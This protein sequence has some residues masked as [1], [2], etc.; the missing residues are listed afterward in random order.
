[1]DVLEAAQALEAQGHSVISFSLGEPDFPAPEVVKQAC[2][3]AILQDNTKYTHSQGLPQLREAIVTHYRKTYGVT[4]DA[5]QIIVTQG[6]S[7]AFFLIFAT[8]LEAGD[9]VILPNPHYPCDA[10]FVTFQG[11]RCRFL[12]LSEE[13]N[14]QWDV[15]KV[16]KLITPRTRGIFVTSPSNPTGSVLMP[17]V[18]KG[19]AK[20]RLPIISDEIYHGLVY[21]GRATSMLEYTDNAFVVNGFSKAYAM[22]GFRLGYVIAP[23][24]YVRAMQKIQ[25]NFYI[26]ANPFVQV[27]GIAALEKAGPDLERMRCEFARRRDVMLQGLTDLGFEVG[28][29]P[30]GAFYIFV[31]CGHLSKKSLPLAF[32]ILAKAH[33]A[34]TPGIDFG[35]RGEGHLRFSYA[36]SVEKI[37]EGLRRLKKYL[38]P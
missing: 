17:D 15:S 22:T 2:I 16:K 13:E 9:S 31:K 11:G 7:P 19:L 36:V 25:Q 10:S 26:S 14:Y 8:L 38:S 29:K 35:S 28:Y 6:T 20:L 12:P 24:K 33:V 4:L 34:V 3:H 1:M 21:D 37:E 30:E 5:E 32:D 23:K 18:L 27:A